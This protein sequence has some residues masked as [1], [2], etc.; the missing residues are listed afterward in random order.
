MDITIKD[1]PTQAI[2]DRI[3]NSAMRIIE[4]MR[5]PSVTAE[6]QAEYETDIDTIR[7]ANELDKKFEKEVTEEVIEEIV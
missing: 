4:D 7:E 5:K 1:V 6:K 3:K 2:A